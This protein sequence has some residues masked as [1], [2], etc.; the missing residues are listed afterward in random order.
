[1][2]IGRW[3]NPSAFGDQVDCS[4][5]QTTSSGN[6]QRTGQRF[7]WY[8]S[9]ELRAN[10]DPASCRQYKPGDFL[11]IRP[12]NWGEIIDQDD[13]NDNS[14]DPGLPSGGRR[15]PSDGNDNDNSEGEEDTQSGEKG[16]GK[17]KST[18]DRKGKGKGK[19]T[20]EG[21]GKRKGNGKGKGIV[22]QTPRGD[23][24][25]CAVAVQL[26]KGMY[27]AD[28]D[29][30]GYLEPV[31]VEPGASSARSIS[32]ED[33]TDWTESD[34]EYDSELDPDVDMRMEDDVD[35]LDGVDLDGDVYMDR[36]GDDYEEED[37]EKEYEEEVQDQHEDDGKE[38][39]TLGQGEMLNTSAGDVDT[40]VDD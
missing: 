40:M 33:I 16:T 2:N 10:I 25:S 9:D 8:R 6:V 22:E 31:Y 4:N 35:A 24:I 23:D 1:M 5:P 29:T 30:E 28:S 37:E 17:G 14:V 38:P 27:D 12:L 39:W 20:E 19:A 18:R 21:K 15:R 34:G 36:D 13:D 7:S 26:Q 3:D 32:S 11:A